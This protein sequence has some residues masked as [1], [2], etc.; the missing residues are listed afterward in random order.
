MSPC[1]R[2]R[3]INIEKRNDHILR[4]LYY[5]PNNPASFS[6]IDQLF[7]AV[8]RDPRIDISRYKVK[9]WLYSQDVYTQHTQS[10]KIFPKRRVYAS[11][12]DEFYDV[13]LAEFPGNFPKAN[14][15][16][17]YLLVM[18]DVLSRYLFVR[19]LVNKNESSII[20]AFDSIF[21]ESSRICSRLRS[22][23]GAEFTSRKV[24]RFLKSK[25][26]IH[27]VTQQ[28]TKAS[29]AERAIKVLK[30]RIYKYINFKANYHFVSVLP[31]IVRSYNSAYNRIIQTSPDKVTKDNDHIIWERTYLSTILKRQKKLK[32]IN[33]R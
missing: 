3:T 7:K 8:K 12:I 4:E 29:F 33:S 32:D 9:K 20:K 21:N 1:K 19:P 15:G 18:V 31:E 14:S 23:K 16:V 27:Y 25:G 28:E 30:Q 11:T 26:I 10:Y 5:D 6:G 22:D 13:D 24:G 2:K 17:R